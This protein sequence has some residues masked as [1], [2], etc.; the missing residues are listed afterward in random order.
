MA[1]FNH[2]ELGG[3]GQWSSGGM[4]MIGDMFNADL[5]KKVAALCADV[6]QLV[7]KEDD[8]HA[9]LGQKSHNRR[10]GDRS[11]SSSAQAWPDGLGQAS[12]TGSQNDLHY[13]FFPE[14]R[15]LAI[16]DGSSLTLYD[17]EDHRIQGVSQQQSTARS[18]RF[19]SQ[20]GDVDLSDLRKVAN[21]E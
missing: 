14:S 8:W 10:S 4:L 21:S 16:K 11:R 15:R 3:L 12:S 2:P 5:K 17:T 13:A 1:Q 19:T 9:P 7:S 6:A 20:N 18:L